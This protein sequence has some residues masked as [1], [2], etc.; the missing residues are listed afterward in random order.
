MST[1]VTIAGISYSVPALSDENWGDNVSSLLIALATSSKVLQSSGGT[2]ALT[3]ELDLGAS[4]GLKS[5]YLKSRTANPASSGQL[6]LA[7]SDAI[8]FRNNANDG[9]LSLSLSTDT[10]QF[11]SVDL[12]DVSTAQTFTNKTHTSPVINTS[13]SGTAILDEDNMASDSDTQIPTQQSVKAYVD[14]VDSTLSS[15]TSNTSNPHSVTKAQVGLTN[16]DDTSDATKNSATATLTNKTIDAAII[17]NSLVM[18]EES[19]S[20]STP[21]SGYKKLYAK[22]DG[23][24]YTLNSSGNEVEVGSGASSSGAK[25]YFDGGD[26]ENGI[27]IASAYNDSGAYVDGTG[28]TASVISVASNSTTPLNGSSDLKI[29]KAASDGS[30]EGVTLLSDT[31]DRADRGR[32]LFVTF[33]WDGT[34]ANYTDGDLELKA[35]DVGTG[36]VILPVYP[37]AGL[38]EDGTLP[39]LKTK[40][41]A[42]IPTTTDTDSTIRVSLHLASDSATGSAWS[43]YL[44]EAKLSPDSVVPGAIITEPVTFSPTYSNETNMTEGIHAWSRVGKYMEVSG[45]VS[46]TGA[47]SGST[48][49]LTIPNGESIDTNYIEANGQDSYLGSGQWND[50]GTSRKTIRVVYGASATTVYFMETTAGALAGTSF[51]SGDELSYRF[52]VP[53]VGWQASAAL[54]TTEA[55][56]Q[57]LKLRVTRETSAQSIS[58]ASANDVIFNNVDYS[59]PYG[60]GVF[61]VSTGKFTAPRAGYYK[62]YASVSTSSLTANDAMRLSIDVNDTLVSRGNFASPVT[63]PITVVQDTVYL[64]KD[65]TVNISVDSSADTSYSVDNGGALT[66]MTIESLPDFTHFA[67]F[68][69]RNKIQT[70]YLSADATSDGTM[71]D[72]TF[73]NLTVGKWYEIRGQFRIRT[74]SAAADAEVRV[75]INH[76]SAVIG[77]IYM[78]AND[79][80]DTNVDVLTFTPNIVFQA[81]ATTLTFSTASA[82]ANSHVQ[83]SGDAEETFVQLE[84]RNDLVET[85]GW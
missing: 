13:I 8:K 40:I 67:V 48:L 33:E 59:V 25:N 7:N 35:F 26:F 1:T 43:C 44:D 15:H 39:A 61:N 28:G 54:S 38:N 51:A 63:S 47:G 2:F 29:T 50:N 24:V 37:V 62:V 49:T 64:S 70:K 4:Y 20:P 31:V 14:A 75:D 46:Y 9:D 10:L 77:K 22:N 19:S 85:S 60:S 6:R 79:A 5:I 80:T 82:S 17:D 53:I 52:K 57:T 56:L 11:N 65:D 36:N 84:E 30:G 74:D 21:S 27:N 72:L 34:D 58:D 12:A 78:L 55:S 66:F 16:V 81:A 3:A 42:Y 71:S 73:S 23:K 45:Y 68:N 83:G 32:N 41:V 18:V 76:N 69:E